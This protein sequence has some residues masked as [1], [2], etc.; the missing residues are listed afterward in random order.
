MNKR[1]IRNGTVTA[2]GR[3]W[4]LYERLADGVIVLFMQPADEAEKY[5]LDEEAWQ[6]SFERVNWSRRRGT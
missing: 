5:A 6:R 2:H 3:E 4:P 1:L